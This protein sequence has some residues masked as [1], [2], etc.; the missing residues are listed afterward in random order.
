MSDAAF[1]ANLDAGL[2]VEK[3]GTASVTYGLTKR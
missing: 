2:V 3:L 1:A